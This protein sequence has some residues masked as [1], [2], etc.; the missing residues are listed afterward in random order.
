MPSNRAV[1]V[2]FA[3]L[4][5]CAACSGGGGSGTQP[6]APTSTRTPTPAPTATPAPTGPVTAAVSSSTNVHGYAILLQQNAKARLTQDGYVQT[7]TI[8]TADAAQFFK[9]LDAYSPIKDIATVNNCLKSA[10]YGTTMTLTYAGSTSG[11]VSCPPS[12]TSPAEVLYGDEQQV[13]KDMRANG[14]TFDH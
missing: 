2:V 11:D 12:S 1:V 10:S 4:A 9:D 3:F 14:F 7:T 5:L 6:A 13:E 8:P